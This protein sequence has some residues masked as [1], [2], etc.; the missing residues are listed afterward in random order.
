MRFNINLTESIHKIES[1][2]CDS[3]LVLYHFIILLD[4]SNYQFLLLLGINF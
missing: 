3:S 1:I 2:F 4:E